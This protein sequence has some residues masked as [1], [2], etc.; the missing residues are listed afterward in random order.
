MY[1]EFEDLPAERQK[2]TFK[3]YRDFMRKY[4]G[5]TSLPDGMYARAKVYNNFGL[6][7]A[8]QCPW[9]IVVRAGDKEHTYFGPLVIQMHECLRDIREMTPFVNLEMRAAKFKRF[10]GTAVQEALVNAVMHFDPSLRKDIVVSCTED[11]MTITSPGGMNERPDTD[12]SRCVGPRNSKTSMLL[13]DLGYA[14]MAGRGMEAIRGCYCTSGLIP[15]IISGS[16]DFSIQLPSLDCT[17]KTFSQGADIVL[18]YLRANCSGN[19]VD[20]SR[21][22]MMSVHRIRSIFDVLEADGKI[23]TLGIGAKRTAFYIKPALEAVPDAIERGIAHVRCRH[24]CRSVDSSQ[25]VWVT[26]FVIRKQSGG[27]PSIFNLRTLGA[28]GRGS[29]GCLSGLLFCP[30]CVSP[31]PCPS[32]AGILRIK[33]V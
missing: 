5:E 23:L 3:T 4:R 28:A 30:E 27:H 19:I 16:D 21:Q 11:L 1:V 10:P 7:L 31:S 29:S 26:P 2:M 20:V 6:M 32:D 14:K 24:P 13:R 9:H 18:E 22:L 8:D 17:T 33:G 15:V 12:G 25:P